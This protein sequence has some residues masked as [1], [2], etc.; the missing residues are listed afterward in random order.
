MFP[1][2]LIK[3]DRSRMLLLGLVVG[4][5]SGASQTTSAGRGAS[6][7]ER[8]SDC[9]PSI[10][11]AEVVLRSDGFIIVGEIHGTQEVPEL[12]G[13]LVCRAA[14]KGFTVKVGLEFPETEQPIA[15]AV[16]RAADEEQAEQVLRSSAFFQRSY[17]D[18]RSSEAMAKLI[19]K[20]RALR[21]AGR[22]V[23][24]YCF[25]PVDS[26]ERDWEM[27]ERIASERKKAPQ[28]AFFVLT[29]NLHARKD[30]MPDF[31]FSPMGSPLVDLGVTFLNLEAVTSGGSAWDLFKCRTVRS[32]ADRWQ[33]SGIETV[34][35]SEDGRCPQRIRRN[36][37]C[38]T[39]KGLST[40]GI[41]TA[42]ERRLRPFRQSNLAR[43]IA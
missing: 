36:S 34:S 21:K 12:F 14:N 26:G 29:G 31:N 41:G 42:A 27:A 28:S 30:K 11:G 15:Q 38:R 20:L 32:L 1:S 35:E 16:F 7:D 2:S 6:E 24:A 17:Q 40:I 18:G 5:L 9:G 33:E 37:P 22:D 3:N 39:G 43:R 4:L 8:V 19:L 25:D 10:E 13:T 23:H